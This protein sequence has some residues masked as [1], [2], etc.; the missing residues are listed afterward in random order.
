MIQMTTLKVSYSLPTVLSPSRSLQSISASP[1]HLSCGHNYQISHYHTDKTGLRYMWKCNSL[2][3]MFGGGEEV[4]PWD[5]FLWPH[6]G[7]HTIPNPCHTQSHRCE[8]LHDTCHVVLHP[9]AVELSVHSQHQ[10]LQTQPN[11]ESSQGHLVGL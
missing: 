9:A 5:F 7:C 3:K 8:T 2:R 11:V 1:Q 6:Y 10:D 4:K